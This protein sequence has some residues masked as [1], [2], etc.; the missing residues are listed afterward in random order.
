MA[1]RNLFTSIKRLV[2]NALRLL[3]P[4]AS[5]PS[6]VQPAQPQPPAVKPSVKKP[7]PV[8]PSEYE[9]IIEELKKQN[10][11]LT[12]RVNE[13]EE[14]VKV[15]APITPEQPTPEPITAA[16]EPVDFA[17]DDLPFEVDLSDVPTEEKPEPVDVDTTY[18]NF[19]SEDSLDVLTD[20]L[21]NT[22]LSGLDPDSPFFSMDP[23]EQKFMLLDY[24]QFQHDAN[25]ALFYKGKR[26]LELENVPIWGSEF[27][28][29]VNNTVEFNDLS[30]GDGYIS[31][32]GMQDWLDEYIEEEY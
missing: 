15:N 21:K 20:F 9:K 12:R 32:P 25:P 23:L 10:E 30:H 7:E 27:D 5:R 19:G 24:V 29:F 28:R 22:D 18:K 17:E 26:S 14:A 3:S 2:T 31:D 16:L 13:L 6:R 8:A 11:E 4:S 1:R